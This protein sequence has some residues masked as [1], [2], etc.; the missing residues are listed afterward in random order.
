MITKLNDEPEQI[1]GMNTQRTFER[2]NVL[3]SHR[4]RKPLKTAL[5]EALSLELDHGYRG[6]VFPTFSK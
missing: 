2:R 6:L 3:I 1:G 5:T 4:H